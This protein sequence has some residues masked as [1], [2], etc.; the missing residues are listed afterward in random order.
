MFGDGVNIAARLQ[1]FAAPDTICLSEVV[2]H[3]VAKKAPLVPVVSLGRP[4]LKNIT[5]RFHVYT[6]LT[7]H[8]TGFRQ[9]LQVQRLKLSHHFGSAPQM[10]LVALALIPLLQPS[11]CGIFPLSDPT[12]SPQHLTPESLPLPDKPSIVVLP[13][14]NMS[15]DPKQEYFSDGITEDI[16][17]DLSKISSLFVIARNS[18]FSYKGKSPKVQDVSGE[19]GVRYVLEGS[20]RKAGEQVRDRGTVNRRYHGLSPVVGTV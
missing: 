1:T 10:A 4:K 13:F 15:E 20:V 11:S 8:P 19:M 14:A 12:P 18:A 2:Y 9:R 7:N 3:E 16:T 17:T 6:L 5:E